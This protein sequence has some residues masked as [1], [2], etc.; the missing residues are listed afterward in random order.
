MGAGA[1]HVGRVD[2]SGRPRARCANHKL[3]NI[4]VIKAYHARQKLAQERHQTVDDISLKQQFEAYAVD[5]VLELGA[6]CSA[7]GLDENQEARL[8]DRFQHDI[9]QTFRPDAQLGITLKEFLRFLEPEKTRHHNGRAHHGKQGSK[10]SKASPNMKSSHNR[11]T[12]S[13]E[14]QTNA[15]QYLVRE[16]E[17]APPVPGQQHP[18]PKI[19]TLFEFEKV[20]T[21]AAPGPDPQA[22]TLVIHSEGSSNNQNEDGT[23]DM[24][25]GGPG[26]GLWKKREVVINEKITEYTKVHEDGRCEKLIESEKHQ[27]EVLHMESPNGDFAHKETTQYEKFERYELVVILGV[28]RTQYRNPY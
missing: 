21:G 8:K 16:E 11:R 17:N 28:H 24:G 13:P 9:E 18:G 25:A 15:G 19:K 12:E 27:Q 10:P 3:R 1:S 2:A 20:A 23:L 6:I 22:G 5:G 26:P 4:L 7:L 14:N